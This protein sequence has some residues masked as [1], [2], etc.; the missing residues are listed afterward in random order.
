MAKVKTFVSFSRVTSLGAK[1]VIY[2]AAITTGKDAVTKDVGAVQTAAQLA[3][4]LTNLALANT[5]YPVASISLTLA[6]DLQTKVTDLIA[7]ALAGGFTVGFKV[8]MG[9]STVEAGEG[10]FFVTVK[11]PAGKQ[12]FEY[13]LAEVGV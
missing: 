6:T 13:I 12:K 1:R 11:T 3:T 7:S 5:L 8:F 10:A 9:P 2:R 4:Y